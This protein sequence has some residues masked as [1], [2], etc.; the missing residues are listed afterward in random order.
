MTW[1]ENANEDHGSTLKVKPNGTATSKVFFVFYGYIIDSKS[2][3]NFFC[4][5]AKRSADA[6]NQH[7]ISSFCE[8]SRNSRE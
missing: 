6:P 7:R 4:A 2:H 5:D 3:G 8:Q 1:R